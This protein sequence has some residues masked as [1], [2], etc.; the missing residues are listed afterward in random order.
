MRMIG[1][2][3]KKDITKPAKDHLIENFKNFSNLEGFNFDSNLIKKFCRKRVVFCTMGKSAYACRK[4]VHSARSFG[5]S[6][7]D[8]DVFHAFHGDAGLINKNDLLV[9]VS[10][11][12]ESQ[13][14]NDV[15]KHFSN[16]DS[17]AICSNK[18]STLSKICND[19]IIVPVLSEG[20]PF[21]LAPMISTTLYM[22]ILH[23][24]L[25]SVIV[26]KDIKEEEFAK[27]H[28]AGEIGRLVKLN[29]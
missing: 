23:S 9:F 26:Y 16:N 28:P 22:I 27:N 2:F 10:K 25:C 11:S 15:A 1:T 12:G 21:G 18:D 14:T 17:I 3:M 4:V 19:N 13:E 5:L 7:H 29:S 8:L 20:S 6:W 24:I